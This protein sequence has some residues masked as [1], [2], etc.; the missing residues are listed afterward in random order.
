VQG[1]ALAGGFFGTAIRQEVVH[2]ERLRVRQVRIQRMDQRWP[3]LNDSNPRVAMAVNS[4][5]VALGQ[6]EPPFQVEVVADLVK[7]GLADE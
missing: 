7:R 4:P 5:L 1:L 3:L 6:A 2:R